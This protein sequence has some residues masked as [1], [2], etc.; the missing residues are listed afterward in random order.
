LMETFFVAVAKTS[1]SLF[2]C[3]QHPNGKRSLYI[4]PDILCDSSQREQLVAV[5]VVAIL[6]Y[7]VCGSAVAIYVLVQAPNRFE[8]EPGFQRRWRFL[9]SKYRP[10]VHWWSA[11]LIARSLLLSVTTIVFDDGKI[12]LLFVIVLLM[13]YGFATNHLKPWRHIASNTFDV[14][15]VVMLIAA[16]SAMF[17][18]SADPLDEIASKKV[19]VVVTIYTQATN[20]IPQVVAIVFCF[21][22]VYLHF[23]PEVQEAGDARLAEDLETVARSLASCSE[24]GMQVK[25]GVAI[26]SEVDKHVLMQAMDVLLAESQIRLF[27]LRKS[28]GQKEL[29]RVSLNVTSQSS[30]AESEDARVSVQV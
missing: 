15:M 10:D 1:M 28:L 8:V 7:C 20:F 14:T 5:A 13:V 11:V 21:R 30:A 4:S 16:A 6:L 12:Q 18:F 29:S 25:N 19:D 23:H 26:L 24:G 27:N 17:R 9:L 3:Y 22:L 2:H